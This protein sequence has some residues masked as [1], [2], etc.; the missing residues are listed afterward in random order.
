MHVY[1][2]SLVLI[3]PDPHLPKVLNYRQVKLLV[4]EFYLL[5]NTPEFF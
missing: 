4:S 2:S 5:T 1:S 3:L